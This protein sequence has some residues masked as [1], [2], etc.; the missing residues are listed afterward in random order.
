[1]DLDELKRR[2]NHAQDWIRKLESERAEAIRRGVG[3]KGG[4]QCYGMNRDA[5]SSA[6]P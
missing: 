5:T 2:W 4:G 6:T 1:M 3:S